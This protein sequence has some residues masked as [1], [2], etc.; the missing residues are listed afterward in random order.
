MSDL[1]CAATLLLARHG[2]AEHESDRL[3]DARRGLTA[4]GREQARA[5]GRSLAGARVAVVYTS[6]LSQAVETA[7]LVA[8]QTGAG[9]VVREGLEEQ[10]VGGLLSELADLHRGETVVTV[11]DIGAIRTTVPALT[12]LPDGF[13]STHPVPHASV[14][15]IVVDGDGWVLRDW[16]GPG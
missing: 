8:A 13:V 16:P 6:P 11:L 12:G 10:S 15:E 9:V 3:P 4:A 14:V 7:E 2:E 5:L 1:Q